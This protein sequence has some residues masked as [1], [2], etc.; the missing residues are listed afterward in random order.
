MAVPAREGLRID[1]L[2]EAHGSDPQI[3]PGS[4]EIGAFCSASGR[5]VL[6]RHWPDYRRSIELVIPGL[7][8]RQLH[9]GDQAVL[10]VACN[11]AGTQ[12]WAV[13]GRW[14]AQGREQTMVLMD[15][16]GRIQ[17]QKQLNPWTLQPGTQLLVDPVRQQLLMCVSE[18]A[19]SNTAFAALMDANTLE[20]S[21]FSRIPIKE[22][23][24]LMP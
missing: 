24:W 10:A 23:V 17:K 22:A 12:I 11:N 20:W 14:S 19:D 5:A 16:T 8:P 4:R 21:E 9:L 1:S 6:I 13:L 15:E 18:N 3:L 7:A 2:S